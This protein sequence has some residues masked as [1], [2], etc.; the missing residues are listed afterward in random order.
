MAILDSDKYLANLTTGYIWGECCLIQANGSF[1][2]SCSSVSALLLKKE[3]YWK[4]ESDTLKI[5]NWQRIGT[6]KSRIEMSSHVLET[7]SGPSD[8]PVRGSSF[9][10][11]FQCRQLESPFFWKEAK[12]FRQRWKKGTA[13]E[14]S[15]FENRSV[16]EIKKFLLVRNRVRAASVTLSSSSL[17]SPSSSSSSSVPSSSPSLSASSLIASLRRTNWNQRDISP[18]SLHLFRSANCN[19]DVNGDD[20]IAILGPG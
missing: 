11:T 14:I 6:K 15:N 2:N 3:L 20:I 10:K 9:R 5:L 16:Q 12:N 17:S 19:Q 13:L 4:D 8:L 18:R 1:C 7:S